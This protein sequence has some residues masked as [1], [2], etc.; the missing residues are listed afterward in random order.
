MILTEE[1]LVEGKSIN[2]GWSRNQMSLFDVDWPLKEGWK[3][4]ILG[5]DYH[6]D[7]IMEFI[8]LKNQHLGSKKKKYRPSKKPDLPIV[9]LDEAAKRLN[10]DDEVY[11]KASRGF[12]WKDD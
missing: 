8:Y 4:E 7:L 6:Q 2:G 10:N 9:S 12:R 3:E 11:R 1:I 5:K